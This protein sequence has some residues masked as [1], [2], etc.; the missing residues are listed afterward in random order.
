MA[1]ILV[2]API[3]TLT[4]LRTM[5]DVI[6]RAPINPAITLPTP[7]ATSSRLAGE[8]LR[9][10]IQFVDGFQVEQCFQRCHDR[11][12]HAADVNGRIGPLG[13]IRKC[14]KPECVGE[15]FTHGNLDAVDFADHPLVTPALEQELRGNSKQNDKSAGLGSEWSRAALFVPK[16]PAVRSKPNL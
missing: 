8:F 15:R 2:F 16:A 9:W 5:T 1:D 14:E 12:R 3:P 11:D 10:R 13:E 6:G 4:E 7:C